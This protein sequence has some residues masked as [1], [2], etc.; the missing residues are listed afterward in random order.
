MEKVACFMVWSLLA[1]SNLDKNKTKI[2]V[3]NGLGLKCK[4][5]KVKKYGGK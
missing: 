2:N 5:Q 1:K 4:P 3:H